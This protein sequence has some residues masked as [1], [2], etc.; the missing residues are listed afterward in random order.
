MNH[1]SLC[2][3]L[4]SIELKSF[5]ISEDLSESNSNYAILLRLLVWKHYNDSDVSFSFISLIKRILKL[6]YIYF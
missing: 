5:L 2:E 3:A 4:N 6:N 1:K